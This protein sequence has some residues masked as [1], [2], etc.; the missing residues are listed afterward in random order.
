MIRPADLKKVEIDEQESLEKKFEILRH[1]D[2]RSDE[3]LVD[4]TKDSLYP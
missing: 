3:E 1:E 2:S 4:I